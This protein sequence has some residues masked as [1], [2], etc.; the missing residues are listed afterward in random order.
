MKVQKVYITGGAASGKT[1]LSRRLAVVLDA[2]VY[3]LDSLLLDGQERGESFEEVSESVA[4][5]IMATD[6]WVA[7]GSYLGWTEPLLRRAE[8]IVWIDVPWR[9]AS[10]RI[11]SRH[12]KATVTRNNRFPGWRRLYRFWRWSSRYYH[13]KNPA[14]LN[15]YGV[16]NTKAAEVEHLAP[17]QDKLVVCHTQNEAEELVAQRSASRFCATAYRFLVAQP[18]EL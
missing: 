18:L 2:P 1:R 10:Y 8:L 5:T 9:V 11:I 16:P 12:I 4:S 15:A 17:Y 14:G 13:D 6:T 3:E 7:E